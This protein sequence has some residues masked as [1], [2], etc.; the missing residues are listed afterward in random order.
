MPI[1]NFSADNPTSGI[2]I[3]SNSNWEGYRDGMIEEIESCRAFEDG[4]DPYRT[5]ADS[6]ERNRI[7]YE[8]I[9]KNVKS[10]LNPIT[11]LDEQNNPNVP[12]RFNVKNGV[13]RIDSNGHALLKEVVAEKGRFSRLDAFKF[14]VNQLNTDKIVT[15]S[16]ASNVVDTDQVLKSRGI[17]EF[18]GSVHMN[19]DVFVEEGSSLNVDN[20]AEITFQEGSSLVIKNG[21]KFEM[22][23][24]TEFK[25][26]GDV[27]LDV[28]R[29]VFVDSATGKKYRI[30]FREAH[31]CEGSGVVME[32][33]KVEDDA[34]E[35]VV[36]QT[37]RSA[38]ELDQKLKSLGL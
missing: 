2:Q 36:E 31:E 33:S 12:K 25:M 28:S 6:M 7:N 32:Y 38:T 30:S 15:T 4:Y 27:E 23:N 24:D 21:A 14:N 22:G 16:V 34:T 20:G 3:S 5:V 19:A 37:E 10:L 8:K 11:Y 9:Q 29:L 35:E 13:Y 1:S 26:A 18:D 17:A